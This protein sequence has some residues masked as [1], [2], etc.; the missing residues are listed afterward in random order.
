M[1][2]EQNASLIHEVRTANKKAIHYLEDLHSA[3]TNLY[4]YKEELLILR[5]KRHMPPLPNNA[6]Q[7]L[8]QANTLVEL[9]LG[10]PPSS[11]GDAYSQAK[12][13]HVVSNHDTL[14]TPFG[15]VLYS[16]PSTAGSSNC[17]LA[18]KPLANISKEY[19]SK[20][21]QHQSSDDTAHSSPYEDGKGGPIHD[22]GYSE[23][24]SSVCS[25][26]DFPDDSDSSE[27][28]SHLRS[29]RPWEHNR[30]SEQSYRAAHNSNGCLPSPFPAHQAKR[31]LVS[32]SGS[33]RA[34]E[35]HDADAYSSRSN[36]PATQD[37]G[38]AHLIKQDSLRHTFESE[39]TKYHHIVN[40]AKKILITLLE[41]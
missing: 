31:L 35:K 19:G 29:S 15:Y 2:K 18:Q 17:E 6:S 37:Q 36:P 30:E 23:Q 11:K 16:L 20:P 25:S 5:S 8:S 10:L 3:E 27:C 38:I 21:D 28:S 7:L 9:D 1:L 32:T 24:H 33:Q 4:F 39:N 26:H 41:H 34:K 40:H 14:E 13:N 12:K 22:S